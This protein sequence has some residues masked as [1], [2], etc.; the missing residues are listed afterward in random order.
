ME[1]WLKQQLESLSLSQRMWLWHSEEVEAEDARWLYAVIESTEDNESY[2]NKFLKILNE[3]KMKDGYYLEYKIEQNFSDVLYTYKG[4]RIKLEK[5]DELYIVEEVFPEEMAMKIRF[6]TSA[7][8]GI[9]LLNSSTVI[10]IE[11]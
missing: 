11:G 2:K 3:K 8:R 6:T 5:A 7:K 9:L 10:I 4:K 1:V